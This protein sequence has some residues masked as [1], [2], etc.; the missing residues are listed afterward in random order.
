[1]AKEPAR[2]KHISKRERE[3]GTSPGFSLEDAKEAK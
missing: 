3:P 1:M 2:D